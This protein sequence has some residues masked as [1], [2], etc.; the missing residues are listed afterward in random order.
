MTAPTPDV[1]YL[2]DVDNTLLDNGVVIADLRR[3][4]RDTLGVEGEERYWA[5]FE[6]LFLNP[7]FADYLGAFNRYSA[8]HPRDPRLFDVSLLLLNYPFRERLYPRALEVVAALKQ[9]GRVAIVSDGD[10][11][12]QPH[13]IKR[14]GLWQAVEGSV[15]VYI[16][17]EEMLLDIERRYPARRY[18]MF[19]DKIF[20]LAA[21]KAVWKERVTT[22]FVRQGHYA[23]DEKLIA[24]SP[25]ADVTIESIGEAISR[26]DS[27]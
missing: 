26:I 1:V 7:G 15:L 21:M 14:S 10:V 22:V 23:L 3:N 27:F 6:D 13:K 25:A 5:I 9:R 18:V 12:Y 11:V 2:L 4:L 19:D 8:E 20:V 24:Q 16:H 17:K